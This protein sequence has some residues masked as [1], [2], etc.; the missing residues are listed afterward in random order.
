MSLELNISNLIDETVEKTA[1]L[2]RRW[3]YLSFI[4]SILY[5]PMVLNNQKEF[6]FSGHCYDFDDFII[7]MFE[8]T[9]LTKIFYRNQESKKELDNFCT[10]YSDRLMMLCVNNRL[11][12]IEDIIVF[13]N[14]LLGSVV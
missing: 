10:L 14:Q 3:R 8:F 5:E 4:L 12:H 9:Q 11:N 13:R 6:F 7:L 2:E 1:R